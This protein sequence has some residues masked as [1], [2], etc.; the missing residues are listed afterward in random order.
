VKKTG[1]SD[2]NVLWKITRS[3]AACGPGNSLLAHTNEEE[4]SVSDLRTAASVY[5]NAV[6]ELQLMGKGS[7]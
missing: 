5:A 6:K 2:M 1:S 7:T 4:I 3:I